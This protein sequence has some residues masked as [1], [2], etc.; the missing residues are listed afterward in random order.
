MN[1]LLIY[2]TNRPL[3]GLAIILV[4]SLLSATQIGNL[5]IRISAE[6][7][8]VQHDEEH[9]FYNRIRKLFGDEQVILVY[10]ESDRLLAPGK[11]K[12]LKTV[13]DE[14]AGYPFVDRVESL[15]NIPWVKTVDGY[16]DKKPYLE[17]LPKTPEEEARIL[18]EARKNPFL[19][20]VLVSPDRN[21]MAAAV[22]MASNGKE[23]EWNEEEIT[24][25]L[26]TAVARLKG[27]YDPAFAIGFPQVRSE[28]V[29]RIRSEQAHLFPLA[30]GALLI[31][32]FLLLRQLIDILLPILSASFSIL[33][34]LGFMALTDI[35]LNVV[36]SDIMSLG[37][38]RPGR[39]AST[40]S[41]IRCNNRQE[42]SSGEVRASIM[43]S[44]LAKFIR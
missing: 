13:L 10:L 27:D 3:V 21:I 5:Q 2:F 16:L 23:T 44:A 8:L 31:A 42:S 35:P 26:E 6:E 37:N 28:I 19:R 32:L 30:I 41:A 1:R 7:M 11:L 38:L 33:W 4:I 34:T 22:I 12:R 14:I 36:T 9:I 43:D 29:Q 24:S 20:H 18:E 15:F 39:T 40:A 25:R 17:K